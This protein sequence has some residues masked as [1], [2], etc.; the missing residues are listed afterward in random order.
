MRTS[1]IVAMVAVSALLAGCGE[2]SYRISASPER[3]AFMGSS[4]RGAEPAGGMIAPADGDAFSIAGANVRESLKTANVLGQ[5]NTRVTQ[6]NFRGPGSPATLVA[7]PGVVWQ[8]MPSTQPAGGAA[9]ASVQLVE[10]DGK[11]YLL[12]PAEQEGSFYT[13]EVLVRNGPKGVEIA[14]PPR[15]GSPAQFTDLAVVTNAMEVSN[16][17]LDLTDRALETERHRNYVDHEEKMLRTYR[18]HSYLN[19]IDHGVE[20]SV[21]SAWAVPRSVGAIR[22]TAWQVQ[23]WPGSG[24]YKCYSVRCGR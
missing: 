12:V 2:K 6:A 23:N 19:L 22:H 24:S 1:T 11:N 8:P 14:Y 3:D 21:H 5:H 15:A 4:P 16:A 7:Q 9:P 18:M 13:R 20:T 17:S 10:Q